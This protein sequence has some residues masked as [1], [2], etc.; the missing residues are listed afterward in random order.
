MTC[1]RSAYQ[2]SRH[3]QADDEN[4]FD[5]YSKG[6]RVYLDPTTAYISGSEPVGSLANLGYAIIFPLH[7]GTGIEN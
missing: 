5:F 4:A 6:D 7:T 2:S 3:Q 1:R